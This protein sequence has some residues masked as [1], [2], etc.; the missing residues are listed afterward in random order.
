MVCDKHKML[1][2]PVI[3]MFTENGKD[4]TIKLPRWILYIVLPFLNSKFN[5]SNIGI[6]KILEYFTFTSLLFIYCFSVEDYMP[7][8]IP[9]FINI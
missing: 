5:V 1:N 7:I 3:L 4:I 6:F 2:S 8:F 9:I